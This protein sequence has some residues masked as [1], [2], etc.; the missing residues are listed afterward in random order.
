MSYKLFIVYFQSK[1]GRDLTPQKKHEYVNSFF[2]FGDIFK[3]VLSI[4]K[5]M[6]STVL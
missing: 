5:R 2:H 6:M 1:N 4:Y 3:N